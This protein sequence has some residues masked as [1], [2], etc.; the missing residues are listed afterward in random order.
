MKTMARRWILI[1]L[2]TLLLVFAPVIGPQFMVLAVVVLAVGFATFIIWLQREI[3]KEAEDLAADTEAKWLE[4]RRLQKENRER[5]ERLQSE[6]VDGEYGPHVRATFEEYQEND[7]TR[8]AGVNF[9]E[10]ATVRADYNE[11]YGTI[12]KGRSRPVRRGKH[13]YE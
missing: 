9:T 4:Y 2:V 11:T 5:R 7:D 10:G 1:V 12:N 3:D 13:H 6:L 8:H